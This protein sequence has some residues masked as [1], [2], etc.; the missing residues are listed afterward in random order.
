MGQLP[1]PEEGPEEPVSDLGLVAR[2]RKKD[3]AAAEELVRRYHQKAYALAYRTCSGDA[4][5]ARDLTQEAFLHVFRNLHKF[6][7]RSSFYTWL[8]QIVVNTCLDGL[9]RQRRRKRT[10][11]FWRSGSEGGEG[12]GEIP[13]EHP[14]SDGD[15][16]P[17]A[18][19]SKNELKRQVQKALG[20][21]SDHQRMVFE[22]K[23][24]EEMSIPEIAKITNSAEG[25]VK[26]HLFRATRHIRRALS[27][28]TEA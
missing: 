17:L 12:I 20:S 6:E 4:E 9:R 5:E 11:S 15:S 14:D 10:F 28:W 27:D 21:L 25:T 13:E 23:V 3:P 1:Y 2:A 22:L 26:S 7:G 19:L 18:T 16:N 24:F 8:Y